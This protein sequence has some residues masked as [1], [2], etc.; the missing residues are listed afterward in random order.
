[1]AISSR[2]LA[3]KAEDDSGH[4]KRMLILDQEKCKPNMPAHQYLSKFARGCGS[5]CITIDKDKKITIL[6]TACMQCLN[7]AK[8]CPGEAVKIIKLPSNLSTNVTHQYGTNAFKLHGLPTPRAGSVLGLLGTNGIGKSTAVKI[9]AGHLKPNL[10]RYNEPPDWTEIYH[11]YRGSDLQNYFTRFLEDDLKVAIKVQLDVGFVKLFHGRRVGDVL[12]AADER[13]CWEEIAT[14]L[15]LMHVL[16]RELQALS[17]GELQRCAVALTCVRDADVYMFD[18]PSSFL[19]ARQRMTVTDVIRSLTTNHKQL[20]AGDKKASKY[21]VVVEHDLAVLDYMSDYICCLYGEPGAYGVVTKIATVRNGINN[22]L[23]GYIPAEN[24]RFRAEELTFSVSA[25]DS[26]SDQIA[27]DSASGQAVMGVVTYPGMSKTLKNETTGSSFTLHVAP[28]SFKGAEII[29]LLGENGCGKTT[30]ME[31]L[32]GQ[33][34]KKAPPTAAQA[35]AAKK[36]ASDATAKGEAVDVSDP[37]PDD[38]ETDATE[39]HSLASL[40]VAYKRQNYAPRLRKFPGTVR[41]LFERTIQQVC[42]DRLFR[43]LVLKPL[44]MEAL[45]NLYVKNLSGGELQRVAITVCLGQPATVYLLD[46]PSAGLDCEQRVMCAKVI[47]RWVVNHLRKT[48]FV[49]EHD[50]VMASTLADRCIVY[51]GEPGVECTANAA[52]PV[53]EGFNDFLKQLDVTFRRDPVNYR[54]R[55]NKKDSSKDREQK[56]A[57]QH[58]IFDADEDPADKLEKDPVSKGSAGDKS[59]RGGKKK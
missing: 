53:T 52:L 11:Y 1:M 20:A 15:D 59:A 17:G 13:E 55:V 2:G 48:A 25:A 49:V 26:G 47:R 6:E 4:D 16:D 30:F 28:G 24:M 22:Y 58:F 45:E 8:H 34:D 43:L 3:R 50:F 38:K 29:G 10:G 44:N 33:F 32:A 31:L 21:I 14:K 23:A 19:D 40:G 57:G 41:D 56:A 5:E 18:E 42:A 12:K 37:D 39:Q 35:A 51:S 27:F 46:E 9:L 36:A 54:P 7:R